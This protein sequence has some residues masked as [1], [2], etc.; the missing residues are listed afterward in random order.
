MDSELIS[1]TILTFGPPCDDQGLW[2]YASAEDLYHGKTVSPES[3]QEL[4]SV[5]G[6]QE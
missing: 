3:C 5:L 2:L 4:M 6:L 1:L